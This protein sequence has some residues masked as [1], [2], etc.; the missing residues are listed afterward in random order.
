MRSLLIRSGIILASATPLLALAA[1]GN[2]KELIELF[3]GLINPLIALLTGLAVLFFVW[4]IVK[5]IL[6]AGNEKHTA[7]AKSAMLY[8]IIGLFVLFSFWGIV[9]LLARSIFG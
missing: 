4:G 7:E 5:Y 6:S 2:L 8:G 3:T 9:Q 1:P